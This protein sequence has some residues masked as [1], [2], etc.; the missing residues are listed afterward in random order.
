MNA[1]GHGLVAV[2][3]LILTAALPT[4]CAGA[5][6]DEWIDLFNGRDLTGW[7]LVNPKGKNGWRVENGVVINQT[8]SS[9][10]C[11]E[12]QFKD[13]T[14][15]CE[16]QTPPR[17]NAG[18]YI[19]NCYEVQI[20]DDYNRPIHSH[21]CGSMYGEITPTAN[22]C[23][24]PAKD[25]PKIAE[26]EWQTFDIHF[27]AARYS[28]DGRKL[29][30]VRVTVI[31]NGTKIIDNAELK[32]PTGAAR[33]RDEE[34][35]GPIL[36]QGDHGPIAYRQLRIRGQVLDPPDPKAPGPDVIGAEAQPKEMTDN[37]ASGLALS[38]R[39]PNHGFAPTYNVYRGESADFPLDKQHLVETAIKRSSQDCSFPADGTYFYRIVAMGMGGIAG[40]PSDALRAVGKTNQVRTPH[41]SEASWARIEGDNVPARNK[42]ANRKPM[43]LHGRKFEQGI[44]MQGNTSVDLN[45]AE[46]VGNNN[47]F[48]FRATVGMD[49]SVPTKNRLIAAARFVVELDGKTVFDSEKMKWADGTKDVDV[50]I[51]AGTRTIVLIVRREGERGSD[52]ASWGDP[53][54][55]RSGR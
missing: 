29:E 35:M 4:I 37:K 25:F 23:K 12:K 7:K 28:E 43:I 6:Q 17:S 39:T 38:W 53:R 14:L 26:N 21:M 27:R 10:I 50:A 1:R 3:C 30:P 45:V 36:L 20:F 42:A 48:H 54:L 51:P 2:A 31:H 46:M 44:G 40:K 15:H 24:P 19:L 55:E 52:N 11:T 34:A 47:D 5:E 22:A 41:L 33:R 16:F 13:F 49:D 9:N 18:I 32:T 8:P